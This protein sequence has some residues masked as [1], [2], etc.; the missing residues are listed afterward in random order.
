FSDEE[1]A[2]M[3]DIVA[4]NP[5]IFLD[6]LQH[7]MENVTGEKVAGSTIWWE[8]HIQL[9]LTL[10][11]TCAVYPCQSA[12]YHADYMARIAGILPECLVFI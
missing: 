6:E 2:V 10:H 12:E 9:G 1:L 11:K 4:N 7:K 3:N 8:L 5:S